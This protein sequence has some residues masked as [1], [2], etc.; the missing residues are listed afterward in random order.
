MLCESLCSRTACRGLDVGVGKS[1][2]KPPWTHS[3]AAGN[4]VSKQDRDSQRDKRQAAPMGYTLDAVQLSKC[5]Q[6]FGSVLLQ[7]MTLVITSGTMS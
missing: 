3:N 7:N 1:L 4:E 6:P 5:L 2:L